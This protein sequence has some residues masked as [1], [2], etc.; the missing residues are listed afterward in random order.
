MTEYLNKKMNIHDT[1]DIY[2]ILYLKDPI[3]VEHVPGK[4]KEITTNSKEFLYYKSQRTP[5]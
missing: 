3:V 1:I 2:K 5:H 4:K